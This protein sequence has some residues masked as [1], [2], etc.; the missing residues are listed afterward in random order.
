MRVLVFLPSA[1]VGGAE[2]MTITLVNHLSSSGCQALLAL[3]A[4]GC[5]QC[6]IVPHVEVAELGARRVRHAILPLV[7]LIRTWR[8]DVVFA[9]KPDANVG[10]ALAWQL[11]GRR[12]KLVL[13]ESNHRTLVWL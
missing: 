9:P 4:G 8:P 7:R 1:G 6:Q 10:L 2:R 12:A 11:A 5:L 13:R 3:G